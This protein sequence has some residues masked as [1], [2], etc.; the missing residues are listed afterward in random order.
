MKYI[1][2]PAL[3]VTTACSGPSGLMTVER[4]QLPLASANGP[5]ERE[6][7]TWSSTGRP[8]VSGRGGLYSD[9]SFSDA[10]SVS[11]IAKTGIVLEQVP[12]NK[13][14]RADPLPQDAAMG[15]LFANCP[16]DASIFSGGSGICPQNE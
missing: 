8:A 4:Q 11:P 14:E 12:V 7:I 2:L 9:P 10:S 3:I 16:P 1:I 15:Q 6:T 13:I 5:V